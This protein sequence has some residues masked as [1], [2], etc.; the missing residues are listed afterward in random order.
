M[1][2]ASLL[3]FSKKLMKL[4]EGALLTAS[5]TKQEIANAQLEPCGVVRLL[6]TLFVV[7]SDNGVNYS[8]IKDF[9]SHGGFHAYWVNLWKHTGGIRHAFGHRPNKAEFDPKEAYKLRHQAEP[10]FSAQD[11]GDA[12]ELFYTI[13][14]TRMGA[15]GRK[16]V[17]VSLFAFILEN[18][19]LS[20]NHLFLVIDYKFKT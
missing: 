6:K 2:N 3:H 9:N 13:G 12:M 18:W 20:H 10:P 4:K 5:S 19:H 8:M 7:F 14:S 15:R 1:I 17:R 11:P 16:E